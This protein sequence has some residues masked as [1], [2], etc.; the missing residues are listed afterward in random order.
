MIKNVFDATVVSEL[1]D[2]INS[3]TPSTK[4]LWGTMSVSKMLAH[5]N[6]TYEMIYEKAKHPSPGF[7]MKFI[8]KNFVKSTV[9]GDKP[10]KQS[11]RTA[12]AFI[13]TDEKD[14]KAEKD[15]LLAHLTITQQL[16]EAHFDGKESHSFG[17]LSV[18]E[19]N[20]MFY[21]HLDHHLRQ[22][23]V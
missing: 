8:L 15:R 6:V 20:T 2:R 22:F 17:V 5:C 4:A 1:S 9:T 13:I 21:K 14:F 3:L 10:Y 7:I 12:P 19:W 16:G 11:L 18:K 23:G